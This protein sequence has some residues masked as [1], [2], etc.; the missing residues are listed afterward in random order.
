MARAR[1]QRGV[2]GD[3]TNARHRLW[4]ETGR[5]TLCGADGFG[6]VRTDPSIRPTSLPARTASSGCGVRSRR[7]T[8]RLASRDA[9]LHNV[10]GTSQCALISRYH[11]RVAS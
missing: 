6:F 5:K 2:K 1:K 11:R 7:D 9:D 8:T 3:A 10:R 4:R